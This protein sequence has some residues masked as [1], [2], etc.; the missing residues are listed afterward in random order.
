MFTVK[1]KSKDLFKQNMIA[2]ILL[3]GN[4]GDRE[5]YLKFATFHIRK[6]I[7]QIIKNSE[8][9]QTEAW[10]G[11]SDRTYLNQVLLVDTQMNPQDLMKHLLDIELKAG[12]RRTLKWGNRTLDLDI[13]FLE[14]QIIK[15][16]DLQIPHP[17]IQNRRFVLTCLNELDS[18]F[19][20]PGIK[21]SIGELLSACPD[22]LKTQIYHSER[23]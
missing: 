12:R 2:T 17:E 5:A 21:Q 11:L 1:Y 6:D 9:Y 15:E 19:L 10:G 16:E 13:L 23:V 20:H 22:S 3:G 7:G 14:E 4:L 18:K 8:V